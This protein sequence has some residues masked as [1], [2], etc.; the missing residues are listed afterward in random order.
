MD[1]RAPFFQNIACV[2]I[3]VLF[4]NPIVTTAAE[5]ALDAQA[6]NNAA[7]TQAANGV[8][9]VNI[10]TPNSSGLSHNKFTDFNVSQQGLILNNSA[11]A[12]VQ[13]QLGGYVMGNPNL[14]GGAA[15]II[16]NEVNGGSPSQLKGYTEV[17][18]KSAAVIVANPHGIS[19]DGCGFINTPRVTL[20]T[21]K[22]VVEGGRLDRFD[23]DGGQISIEGDGLNARNVS[24]FDLITRSAQINAELHA[25]QL[26]VITGRNDVD[27]ASL[28]AT[29][30]ADDGSAKP[31][32]A[33][34]S[35]ALGGMYAGAIRLVGTEAGVG[36]KLAGDMAASAGDIQIDANGQLS[37]A[38]TAASRDLQLKAESIELNADTFAGRNAV[39]QASGQTQV[40]ESLAAAQQLTVKGGELLNQGVVEA[41]VRAD[42]SLN[43]TATLSLQT[44][45]VTN[46]GTITS[47]GNLNTDVQ[48]LDNRTGKLLSAGVSTLNAQT[49]T[50]Q[51][52]RIVAQK[53]LDLSGS[54]LNNQDGEVL[55]QQAIK[56]TAA[57]LNNQGGT[58]AGGALDLQLSANLNN[59]GGLIE[60]ASDLQLAANT[61]S[62]NGGKLRA[63]GG[64]G[65]SRF[66]LGGLFNNDA[67]LVEIG[68]GA[69][70]LSSVGLSNLG[71]TVRHVG[72]QGFAIDL[73]ALGQAGGRF[74]T[75]GA[76]DLSLDEWSNI[77]SLQAKTL[78]IAINRLSQSATGALLAVDGITTS[79][80]RWENHGRIET[81]G[82]LNLTLSDAYTGNGKLL[83][84]GD[85]TLTA[86]SADLGSDAELRSAGGVQIDITT[87]LSSAGKITSG[88]DLSV[89]A[90]S[91]NNQGTLGSAAALHIEAA[92]LINQGG[93]LFSGSNMQ[94]LADRIS[95]L[96]ADIY[97]LG[98]LTIAKDGAGN[99]S[100]LLENRSG[101]IESS[102]DMSL[103]AATLTNRKEV[104]TPGKQLT[105]GSISV[106]CH[107]C[108][109]D[110]HNVDYVATER[111]SIT[112]DQDSAAS[113]IHS[114]GNLTIQGDAIANRYSS[115]SASGN[116]NITGITLE[117]MGAASGIIER[118]RRFNT[119]R[120]TDGTD[121]RF[122][123]NHINPYNAA[124]LPKE[125]PTALYAWTLT[126]D[127]ETQTP[128]GSG[129]PAIIQAGGNV[130]IQATQSL[131]NSSVLNNQAAQAGTAPG[132][133]TQVTGSNQPL[134]VQLNAQLPAGSQQ[135]VVDPLALPGFALPQGQNGLFQ[136]NNDPG[137]PY[138][139]ETNPA[140]A[141]L[142]NFLNS[143]YLLDAVGYNPDQTQR[144]LGDGLY[145]QRLI[146]QAIAARTG[147][148]FL[149][150]L[151]SDEAQFK[152][153]MDNAIAS[154]QALNLAPGI[155][156]TAEQVAA[157]THDI[158]WMQEQVVNGQKVLVPVLYLAQANDR[159][160]PGGALIQGQDVA[161]ISGS[162]LNNSGTLR[163]TK[164][165]SATA[166]NIGN[167]GLMQAGE[168]LALLATDSIRNAQGGIIA[169]KD[170]TAIALT[171]DI[172]NERTIT[173]E[174]RSGRN[175]SQF[176]SVVDKAAGIEA[177]NDLTLSAGRDIQNI[178]GSLK[179]GGNASLSA[180]QDLIIAS[181]EAENGQM[182][183]DKRH[184]WSSTSTTQYGSDVQV[185]GDLTAEAGRDLAVIASKV[186][187]GGDVDLLAGG[188]VLIGAAANE[189]SSEYRY[190]S[191]KK[192]I[193][194]E[195][196]SVRQQGSE[197]EAGGNFTSASGNDTIL[198]GSQIHA[199][200]EAYLY[201]R[202]NIDLDAAQNSDYSY[203]YKKKK[204][205]MFS[206]S[207]LQMSESS[208]SQSVSSYITSGSDLTLHADKDIA[209]RG[210]QLISDSAIHLNAGGD[211]VLDAAQNSSSQANAK[212]K[213]GFFSS[214]A[215]S[216][217]SEATTLTGTRL[218]GQNIVIEANDDIVLRAAGLRADDAII[219]DAGRDISV[220]TAV[221]SQQSSQASKSSSLKW[222]IF[223]SLATNGSLTFEQKSKGA[224]SSSSQEVGSTLSGATID[225]TSGRDTAVRGSTLVADSDI[226]VA[227]GRNLLITSGEAKD[228]SRARS[229]S[230]NSGEIGDWWQ[231]ATGVVSIKQ[232]SQN[233]T[234]QQL[235]S[236]IASLGGDVEL[237][238]GEAYRQQASQVIAPQGDVSITAKRVDIEAGYDLL[239][240]SQNQSSNRT[241]VGGTV[242]VPLIEAVQGAQRMINAA[243]DTKD[244]RLNALAAA[245]TAMSGYQAYQ[246]AQTLATGDF[247][248]VKISVNLSNSQSKSGGT[249]SGQNVVAS[250]VAA[251][252]DVS[253]K[254]TGD[255]D[256]SNLN[257]VGSTID[258]GRNVALDADG[259]INLVSAQNTASQEGKNNNSGW[260]AGVGFG[261]GQQNGFTLE[262]AA[263]KGKG[264]SEG[265]AITHANTLVTAGE[266]VALNSGGDTNLKGA[267][268]TAKQVTADVGGDL[269]LAS[270][271]DIDNYK[272]KQQN[273]GVGL[274]LCIPPFCAGVSTVSGSFSQQKI[275]SEYASVGQQ[276]GIKA[277]DG[278]F[279]INVGGNTD[280][281][282]AIIASNDKAVEDGK[283]SLTTAT[284]THSDIENKAEYKG[285]SISLSGSYSTAARDK[286]GNVITDK[287]G[288]PVQEAAANA[289]TPIA[290]SASGKDKST[291][292]SGISAGAITITDAAK[293]QELTGQTAE[294]AVAG[295]NRDV[296]SDRDGTN[297]LKPIFDRKEIEAGFE[298]T[299][300]FV[301]NVGNLL[302][303]KAREAD[304]K[305]AYAEKIEAQANDADN[306]LTTEQ[307]LIL[308]G[309]A[310]VL[311]D[312]AKSINDNW[313]AGGTYRQIATVLTAAAGGQVNAGTN[314]FAQNM[315]VNY[316]QQQGAGYIGK[317]VENGSLS[318]GS[319]L[320]AA[321]H[322]IVGCGAAA[323]SQQSCSAGAMGA[324]ASSVL[325]GV[326]A[327]ASPDESS[328]QREAKRNLLLSIITGI[329]A[330]TDPDSA[331]TAN[332]AATA[333]V[334]NNWLATQQ[335][336][337][338]NKELAEA[339]TLA[340]QLKI[341]A[342]WLKTSL[343][344][345][346]STGGGIAKGLKD[347]LA[348]SGLDTLNTVAR[349]SAFPGE[350]L[351]EI[352]EMIS[353]PAIK[354]LLGAKY[355]E[356]QQSIE[357][358]KVALEIGGLDHAEQLGMQIGHIISVAIT[359]V[360]AVEADAV[361]AAG[362]AAKFGVAVTK[363]QASALMAGSSGKLAAQLA[364]IEKYGFDG[365]VPSIPKDV[366]GPKATGNPVVDA[367]KAALDRIA[368][369]PKGP[370][371]TGKQPGTVLQAQ[372]QKRIDDLAVQYN[373]KSIEP[374]DFQLNL[375]GKVLKTDPQVSKGAPVYIGAT[376]SDVMSYF[377]QLAGV[378]NM[379]VAKV[380]PGKG[381][382]YTAKT[383][384][385]ARITL[386][387]FSTSSQQT[388]A[389]WT[390]D[391]MDKSINGGRMVE[392]KFK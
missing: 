372:S 93:L 122:R 167:S 348:G 21:G 181:A 392:I 306:G 123:E 375:G 245:N 186:K 179:A 30:K 218:D 360:V 380:I 42:G 121:E 217:S 359:L 228:D 22:P 92:Q 314:Q 378:E 219:L 62:N 108:S 352:S 209:A 139:I 294:Q 160:A 99:K 205:G 207:K 159:L 299:E 356:M 337:Q 211:V 230:K 130:S 7:L 376:T 329:A 131:T 87:G 4:L 347:G 104:F 302:E 236:Q 163:A 74:I 193:N 152:Y 289:G 183:K 57:N 129:A 339:E 284:L 281:Q 315:V 127:I 184:F 185:G 37:M 49:L 361:K 310:Q 334:D 174:A 170:V 373:A 232:S 341:H 377:R 368:Q 96:Y 354:Q 95:N 98:A 157:L 279:Q 259:N 358:A 254:A 194:K 136:L 275:N 75:N 69:F 41:G 35:S 316:L 109:G 387:D 147:K 61:L 135:L 71:G 320:H 338:R 301:R 8:P 143:G 106:V 333:N 23:V 311:R 318:E 389:S 224:Q 124:A 241:A 132:L 365:D 29:T 162:N 84:Q 44:S 164:N 258:A 309:Q 48:S 344:Q 229:S 16:L 291:T 269:N 325:T 349:F 319:P 182:R 371:L 168:R 202:G 305:K 210:A 180:G 233:S 267:V 64:D 198:V 158:V 216:S 213:S 18:G 56:V 237:K 208:N 145:E 134:V 9:M 138:L 251:G 307:R 113:R 363:E 322:A 40:K 308:L 76:V 177:S 148:R 342:K 6:G 117:N 357:K 26:N 54:Q 369:N 201:A 32:L 196:A 364:T 142:S 328:E 260:S 212:A 111:F 384:A 330:V 19:C 206:S 89:K 220:G 242:S 390:I 227:A 151:N 114:G 367:E 119:G 343:D 46:P 156:L 295:V 336:V 381:A 385:G 366:D 33:I 243:G 97:S 282:G 262:L 118:I 28:T 226:N 100:T 223:D 256:A 79:G 391:V 346:L 133:D 155:A 203:F 141:S 263:N 34:D 278:G 150:G 137:Y 47:H 345:D 1:V 231:G 303:A 31:Q 215:K 88:N 24:Q 340:E 173:Q 78:N 247:T 286:A 300:Q 382:I 52:G 91:L 101:S 140:F 379:P 374:K 290:L 153:L 85:L 386:R 331:A 67:G 248:G 17:A 240:S 68:S 255:G 115:L 169:G 249:Q 323:A 214:K 285:S 192:K 10:A 187:A 271:Q 171:G 221:A 120:V 175:F 43:N 257:V 304:S 36:V 72:D 110:K 149:A 5:L 125:V 332:N 165:L 166:N 235:G 58:L 327:E 225:V 277:G 15:N 12:L 246:S 252:R 191:S 59:Q 195:D 128:N 362:Q 274:S 107:D 66:V 60:S 102:S 144:R 222:H 272:S 51:G 161:L 268:V 264:S 105:A 287:D 14:T 39:V 200:E 190:K 126:S 146:Q 77:S 189:S 276:T 81:D 313:G 154:K 197:I 94:L 86:N 265:E 238:A 261:V 293:Q 388:G 204:G 38:R 55:A 25:N 383:D 82:A 253:I 266:K 11:Q 317:L 172:R 50:N 73:T 234:T 116:I 20:S 250:S 280:L 63:L 298:I 27:A 353:A 176:T 335:K 70:A 80:E 188:D 103:R 3:G 370:D 83:A 65:E 199:G 112:V 244:T 351:D 292:Q 297:T 2:L 326:F 270:Q 324:A 321:L 312:E 45:A 90:A 53:N 273:A 350:S 283:N 355:D 13:T 239:S 178:G 288:K 296:S